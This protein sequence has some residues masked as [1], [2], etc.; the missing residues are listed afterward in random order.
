[1]ARRKSVL[2]RLRYDRIVMAAAVLVALICLLVTCSKAGKD[3][4]EPAD[5]SIETTTTTTQTTLPPV[6]EKPLAVYLSPSNQT[7]NVYAGRQTDTEASVMRAIAEVT[8]RELEKQGVEVYMATEEDSLADKVNTANG[9]RVGTYVAIH[10]NAG[11]SSG[12]G[13]GTEIYYNVDISGSRILAKNVYN[14]VA[15]LTPTEDR[16]MK[17]GTGGENAELYEVINPQMACCLLEVEFHDQTDLASWIINNTEALGKAIAD[18]IMIY[19]D[20]LKSSMPQSTTT[21]DASD[22]TTTTTTTTNG[23]A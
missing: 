20:S 12:Y 3:D 2:Q 18:G 10:S 1:M 9:L 7:D 17:L 6:E 11:G 15:D 19:R 8:K 23:G 22:S 5:A 13:Q 4:A 16:G 21:T 14:A